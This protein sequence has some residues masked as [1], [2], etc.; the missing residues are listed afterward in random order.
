[1]PDR[2]IFT[3]QII[4]GYLDEVSREV[5]ASLIR[6]SHSLNIKE[7]HDCSSGIFDVTGGTVALTSVGGIH[8]GSML[9]LVDHLLAAYPL[10]EM[11]PGDVF[12]VNDPYGGGG[13]HLPD[14]TMAS[15][16]I[17]AGDVIGF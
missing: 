8:L 11:S 9:G 14:F 15:P 16:V 17:H 1:M 10:A 4:G 3:R 6:A 13:S 2:N 5:L 7:R 12:L